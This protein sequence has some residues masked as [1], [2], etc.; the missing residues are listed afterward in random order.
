MATAKSNAYRAWACMVASLPRSFAT[1]MTSSLSLPGITHCGVPGIKNIVY[2]SHLCHFYPNRQELIESLVP[3]FEAGLRANERCLW[4]TGDP[5]PAAEAKVELARVVPDVQRR[6]ASGQLRIIDGR[7]WYQPGADLSAEARV[8]LWLDEEAAALGAGFDGLRVTG[9]VNFL[10]AD[11]WQAFMGYERLVSK[12]FERRR[13]V[14]LCSY[15]LSRCQPSE[16]LDVIGLHHHTLVRADDS[17]QI[18][19]Y[20]QGRL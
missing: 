9:N 11:T 20:Q 15:D 10:T 18:L 2:G 19:Q 5:L 4:V 8:R 13:I 3:F 7:E 16:V 14:A 1:C 17:W 6:I 12:A